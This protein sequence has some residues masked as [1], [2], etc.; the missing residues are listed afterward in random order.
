[1]S[2]SKSQGKKSQPATFDDLDEHDAI[3]L[4]TNVAVQMREDG[5]AI[6]VRHAR[7]SGRPGIL[8]F[9]PGYE[10]RDGLIR[11]AETAAVAQAAGG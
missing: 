8:I 9:M 1:M 2:R 6:D 4:L 3:A 10:L 5:H 11:R 7:L